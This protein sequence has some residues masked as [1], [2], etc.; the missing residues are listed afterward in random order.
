[1]SKSKFQIDARLVTLLSQSYSS[2][3]QALKELI[4]NAWDADADTVFVE[5]PDQA[6]TNTPLVIH[7][8]GSGMT[9]HELTHEYLFIASD[10]RK[11]RGELTN[12]F[13]R[14]VKGKKGIGKFAGLMIADHMKLET[15]AKGKCSSFEISSIALSA[16]LELGKL[17]LSIKVEDCEPK[18]KGTKITLNNL[19]QNLHIP[20][21]EKFKSLLIREYGRSEDFKIVINSKTL[22]IDDLR[23]KYH[24]EQLSINNLGLVRL[25]LTVSSEK[26]KLKQAGISIRV[27]GKIIGKPSFFGLDKHE[28]FPSKLLDKIYG[29]IEADWLSEHVTAD[30]G[31]FIE[32]SLLL[33]KLEETIQ[34]ILI[35]KIREE[36][37][38]DIDLANARL[39][40][41]TQDRLALLPEFKRQFAD[42]AIKSIL[43]KYYGEPDSKLEPIVNVLLDSLEKSDYRAILDYINEAD[44]NDISKLAEAL[45][46]FGLAELAII[47]EQ[48][49]TRLKFLDYFEELC[50][51]NETLESEVH[52]SLENNLWILGAQ[53]SIFSSNT[54]LKKQI[55]KYLEKHYSGDRADKRPD[56]MLSE[57]YFSQYLL[58][59][60]KRPKHPLAFAD[61]QQVTHYRHDFLPYTN[62]D[63]KVM[64]IG[65]KRSSELTNRGYSEPNVEILVFDEIIST[66]RNQLNWLLKELGSK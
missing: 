27:Q 19:K 35:A 30:W 8:F 63:I 64:L 48:T 7:D 47:A 65:G 43:E 32:N 52:K 38:H 5:L 51:E 60:F 23:G 58:I 13:K 4:D 61:Y 66:A 36:Y 34:P 1:M 44:K 2:S 59:E 3:E 26:S 50:D 54:T 46:D 25:Q 55:N 28:S 24:D 49:K 17:D 21:P 12:L 29:E 39:R 22:D 9:E 62:K 14:K 40:K 6:M 56:L 18:K 10:R 11:R 41:K 53:Y 37:R 45:S 33:E 16:S 42:K 20:N 57:N 15:W 31:S